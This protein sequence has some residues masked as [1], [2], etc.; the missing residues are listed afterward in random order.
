MWREGI[1]QQ[2]IMVPIYWGKYRLNH[3]S[4]L[5]ALKP[6]ETSLILQRSLRQTWNVNALK[7]EGTFEGTVKQHICIFTFL[8]YIFQMRL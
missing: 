1:T 5:D 8:Y 7:N 4:R 2:Q 6:L 3:I